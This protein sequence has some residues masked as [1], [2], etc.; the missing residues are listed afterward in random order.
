VGQ[1]AAIAR[2]VGYRCAADEVP[3][4]ITRLLAHFHAQRHRAEP[5]QK[6]LARQSTD[7]LRSIL[8]GQPAAQTEFAV[9]DLPSDR[10]PHSIEDR[11]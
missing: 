9:R 8:S 11:P 7:S 4:A 1:F 3:N 10:V 5:L 6:F 2:P